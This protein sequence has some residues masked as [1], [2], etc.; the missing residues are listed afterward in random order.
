MAAKKEQKQ[1]LEP[2]GVREKNIETYS[3]KFW[4]PALARAISPTYPDEVKAAVLAHKMVE[5]FGEEKF[6]EGRKMVELHY[7]I[8]QQEAQMVG[9]VMAAHRTIM[10]MLQ[11]QQEEPARKGDHEH[12]RATTHGF[13]AIVE[14]IQK[15]PFQHPGVKEEISN[16]MRSG[17]MLATATR[18]FKNEEV[19]IN[20]AEDALT[21]DRW[22]SAGIPKGR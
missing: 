19:A 13:K 1:P 10:D 18:E 6:P 16:L 11:E 22:N 20:W 2:K 15:A 8:T 4:E 14:K 5:Q 21:T 9:H 7:N 3:V 17:R 12:S